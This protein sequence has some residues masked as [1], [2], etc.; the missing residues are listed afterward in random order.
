MGFKEELGISEE[1][2]IA[3]SQ[4]VTN[5][6]TISGEA[7]ADLAH[8]A[9]K[10]KVSE[11]KWHSANME[12]LRTGQMSYLEFLELGRKDRIKL[13]TKNEINIKD[14]TSLNK[15]TQRPNVQ[16]ITLDFK[17]GWEKL[18]EEIYLWTTAG[19]ILPQEVSIVR[20]GGTTYVRNSLLWEFFSTDN[21]RLVIHQWTKLSIWGLREKSEIDSMN[22]VMNL[23]SNKVVNETLANPAYKEMSRDQLTISLDIIARKAGERWID[24]KLAFLLCEEF[25]SSWTVAQQEATIENHLTEIDRV[26]WALKIKD[27]NTSVEWKLLLLHELFWYDQ[28]DE[29]VAL[30]KIKREDLNKYHKREKA[31]YWNYDTSKIDKVDLLRNDE[32]IKKLNN[33]CAKLRV[34]PSHLK[35][36]IWAESKFTPNAQNRSWATWLIQFMPKTALSLWTTVSQ[37]KRMSW[38]D[39]LDFVYKYYRPYKWRIW[40]VEDLYLAT[41]YPAGLKH[42]HNKDWVIWSEKSMKRAKKVHDQNWPIKKESKWWY[43]TIWSF[44]KYVRKNK[45]GAS[46]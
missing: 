30:L 1:Q 16:E 39:Q 35:T 46:W 21:K 14:L 43:I 10:L 9:A 6:A 44:Y 34:N 37:L 7:W 17:F 23:Q 11:L 41:F 2:A 40:S 42:R 32:F 18:N 28:L 27:I 36:V 45:I 25:I 20:S 13:C 4:E 3:L 19:Q 15:D 33:V 24:R 29:K 38:I 22:V 31:Q 12:A 5:E 26:R 8:M